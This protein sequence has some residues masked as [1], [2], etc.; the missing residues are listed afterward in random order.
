MRIKKTDT[1]EVIAGKDRG[2]RGEVLRVLPGKNRVI[3]QGFGNVGS[4]AAKL[5]QDKG[6]KIV[7]VAE[8]EGGLF[9]PNG[10]DVCALIEYRQRNGSILGFSSNPNQRKLTPNENHKESANRRARRA[11][12]W[13]RKPVRCTERCS[14]HRRSSL[15]RHNGQNQ[16]RHDR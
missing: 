5:M 15:D 6:Y 4:N 14:L 8:Y 3:V 12:V 11:F 16:G 13:H 10:I 7:G 1:V 2:K 9:N